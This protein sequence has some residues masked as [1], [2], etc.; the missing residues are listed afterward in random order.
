LPEVAA[1]GTAATRQLGASELV[2]K[3][4]RLG[5][6]EQ[7]CGIRGEAVGGPY[8][9]PGARAKGQGARRSAY[10][11]ALRSR[12]HV[13]LEHFKP[14]RAEGSACVTQKGRSLLRNSGLYRLWDIKQ[15]GR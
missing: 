13:G 4:I 11:G 2:S 10:R 6:S 12:S 9:A 15:W 14:A 3:A 1:R 8:S 7:F 5:A